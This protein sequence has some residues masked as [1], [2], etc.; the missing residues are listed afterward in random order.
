MA[1]SLNVPS[2]PAATYTVSLERQSLLFDFR[3]D[4]RNQAWYLT[5]TNTDGDFLAVGSKLTP[6]TP[7][8][9]KNLDKAPSGNLFVVAT[10]DETSGIP[11]RD[12]IGPTKDYRLIYFTEEEL[13][14]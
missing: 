9:R 11:T 5:I 2:V 1:L 12:N 3:W 10:T 6:D 7:L 13:N 4:T 8:I 14:G